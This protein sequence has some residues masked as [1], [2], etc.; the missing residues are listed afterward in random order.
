MSPANTDYASPFE[1]TVAGK[2]I[3]G[4]GTHACNVEHTITSADACYKAVHGTVVKTQLITITPKAPIILGTTVEENQ[5]AGA[6]HPRYYCG[7]GT[8]YDDRK[9][10][11]VVSYHDFIDRC[12]H[13]PHLGM[14]GHHRNDD[15]SCAT[16]SD[17][18]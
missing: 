14:C 7:H 3:D 6:M 2:I 1:V 9:H 16:A 12:R 13:E 11:C 15:T 5:P 4:D 10:L 18:A 8:V 17:P